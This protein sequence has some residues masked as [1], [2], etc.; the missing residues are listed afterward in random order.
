[1]SSTDRSIL[2]NLKK[3]IYTSYSFNI[4]MSEDFEIILDAGKAR[5]A[6]LA[7]TVWDIIAFPKAVNFENRE[8]S[9]RFSY[10]LHTTLF[11]PPC[12]ELLET[13]EP[14]GKIVLS[15][16]PDWLELVKEYFDD[17]ELMDK[18][19][20]G[21]DMNTFLCMEL[22]AEDFKSKDKYEA[23]RLSED[24]AQN[25]SFKQRILFSNSDGGGVAIEQNGEIIAVAFTPH[26]VQNNNFSFAIIRGVWVDKNHRNKGHGYDVSAKMCEVLFDQ[27]IEVITLWV[28]ESNVPAISIYEKMGF[29]TVDKVL[30]IDCMKK[31]HK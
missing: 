3:E 17:F 28:E 15:F 8:T 23:K 10:D 18:S 14:K 19:A 4:T 26:I 1:M 9:F 7:Y 24:L 11:G 21:K 30:G 13:Y 12:K 6:R 2:R 29:K 27:S 20:K 5:I 31:E 16:D 25:L 22:I